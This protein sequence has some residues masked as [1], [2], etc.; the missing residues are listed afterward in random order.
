MKAATVI[1]NPDAPQKITEALTSMGIRIL[2][3]PVSDNV[4]HPLRGHPDLQ[5]FVHDKHFFCHHG[6]STSFIN[7]LK[8]M[9]EV[10]ISETILSPG[11]P[12]DIAFNVACTEKS[13]FHH[14]GHT[15]GL[16][17]NHLKDTNINLIHVSQGYSK[18]STCI[19]G[20]E[21]II[22]AD[23]GIHQAAAANGINS[24]MINPGHVS[25]PGYRYG[26]IGGASGLLDGR[27]FFTGTLDHHPDGEVI[28]SFLKAA[29]VEPVY[30]SD[31]P[32]IDL[33]S[34][35]FMYP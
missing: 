23:A 9:G 26:F 3:L 34:L 11:Y 6:L 22:T 8:I 13:A 30:L 27:L 21:H 33:G 7:S 16:I 32:L 1:I 35:F 25:L 31:E 14:T 29:G 5:L 18:C 28:K 20:P 4:A 12:G 19:A 2:Y 10:K 15:D 17:R 24:L